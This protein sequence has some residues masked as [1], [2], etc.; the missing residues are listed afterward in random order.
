MKN[1][2]L[3]IT[4][5]I[6]LLSVIFLSGCGKDDIAPTTLNK[7]IFGNETIQI[8]SNVYH[9][10]G[11][12]DT[13]YLHKF[14]LLSEGI[15]VTLNANNVPI[16][17]GEGK[18]IALEVRN[19]GTSPVGEYTLGT[20]PNILATMMNISTNKDGNEDQDPE[21]ESGTIIISHQGSSIKIQLNLNSSLGLGLTGGFEGTYY[22]VDYSN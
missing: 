2:I 12:V 17:S 21:F 5:L 4:T 20:N 3:T 19:L 10:F 22:F 1:K 14:F 7:I 16:I 11:Q 18:A 9:Y 15:E 8:E 13:V 6:T